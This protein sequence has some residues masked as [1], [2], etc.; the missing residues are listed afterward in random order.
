MCDAR[1]RVY[2]SDSEPGY[3][4]SKIREWSRK[5]K[6][7]YVVHIN[8]HPVLYEASTLQQLTTIFKLAPKI[9]IPVL[10]LIVAP[11]SLPFHLYSSIGTPHLQLDQFR[12]VIHALYEMGE[13]F[14][15][16]SNEVPTPD[17]LE[18]LVYNITVSDGM[19]PGSKWTRHQLKRLICWPEWHVAEKEQLDGM[20]LANMF[21]KPESRPTGATI[22]R[23]FWKYSVKHYGRKKARTCCDGSVLRS[24]SLEYAEQCYDACISQTGMGIFFAYAVIRGWVIVSGDV[25]NAYAQTAIPEGEIQYMASNPHM[26]DWWLEKHGIIL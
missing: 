17:Q 2:I 16:P 4:C 10:E 26:I 15:M 14:P 7:S 25:V 12:T 19:V 20:A 6:G 18:D 5:Y 3:T 13:G 1:S 8:E 23:F 22:L 21:G 9:S 11:N 24:K